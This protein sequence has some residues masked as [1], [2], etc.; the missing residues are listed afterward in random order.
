M[1]WTILTCLI[2]LQ[3]CYSFKGISIP[4]DINTFF[5]ENFEDVTGEVPP[6]F[7]QQFSDDLSLKIRNNSRLNIDN[8]DA[9]L[10]FSGRFTQFTVRAE[11]PNSA[12]GTALNKLYVK[13]EVTKYNSKTEEEEKYRYD[14]FAEFGADQDFFDVQEAILEDLTERLLERIFNDSFTNW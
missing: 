2:I 12:T 10:Y 3:S 4:P 7:T 9:D 11:D 13:L 6:G 8:N 5:I 14:E 1:R